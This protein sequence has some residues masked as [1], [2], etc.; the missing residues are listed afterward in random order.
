MPSAT[1]T[2][3]RLSSRLG[4]FY[5]L[6][7]A[8]IGILLPYWS[9]YLKHQGF[10]AEQI[11][12][13][14]AIGMATKLIAPTLW[15]WLGDRTGK[16][17]LIVQSSCFAAAISFAV[18][19]EIAYSFGLLAVVIFAYHFFWNAALPQFEATTLSHLGKNSR[20]YSRIRLWGSVGFVATAISF[21]AL[22]QQLNLDYLPYILLIFFILVGINSLSIPEPQAG[23]PVRYRHQSLGNILSQTAVLVVLSTSVLMLASH[24]PYYGFFSIYLEQLDYSGGIIG[25]LWALGVIAEIVVFWLMPGWLERYGAGCLLSL[26][27]AMTT[28]RWLSIGYASEYFAVLLFA[29]LLHGFSYGMHHAVSIHLIF[30]LFG[31]QHQGRGQALYSSL[32]FGVGGI[33]GSLT[34]GYLWQYSTP[35]ATYLWAAGLSTLGWIII[36]NNRKSLD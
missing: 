28:L 3:P 19:P 20:D 30:R 8:A 24:G 13:L 23:I 35:A 10:S 2:I 22:L 14:L 4:G 12:I 18:I 25:G 36:Y 15:G 33:L 17:M 1:E 34:A 21:G 5:F 6:Y 26:S 9:L 11:G 27:F 16:R 29:Q 31:N 32:S 7:F